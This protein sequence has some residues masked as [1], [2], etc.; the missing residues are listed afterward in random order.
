MLVT[1]VI[2]FLDDVSVLEELRVAPREVACIFDHLLEVSLDP[3]L[4]RDCVSEQTLV[5]LG[6]E[7]WQYETEFHV[8]YPSYIAFFLGL[9]STFLPIKYYSIDSETELL[10]RLMV[11]HYV[12][13]TPF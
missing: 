12:P 9:F 6:S 5:P 1:P 10:G 7:H 4:L 8:S 13:H 2:A 11:G 3:E